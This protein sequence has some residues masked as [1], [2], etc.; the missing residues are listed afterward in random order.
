MCVRLN[1]RV[2]VATL[3]PNVRSS[4]LII[5]WLFASKEDAQRHVGLHI[6]WPLLLFDFNQI[7]NLSQTL[8]K[9]Y[10][11]N[12][13]DDPFSGIFLFHA[14]RQTDG[15]TI[16][17][18]YK[19]E[20][21]ELIVWTNYGSMSLPILFTLGL[22]FYPEDRG[23]RFFETWINHP[24]LLCILTLIPALIIILPRGWSQLVSRKRLQTFIFSLHLN[25]FLQF[26]YFN[27]KMEASGSSET[28]IN[29]IRC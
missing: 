22:P 25:N 27:L 21:S 19:L 18:T 9:L 16:G 10:T 17:R 20:G 14:H 5:V 29:R 7:W 28:W 6:K 12:V 23:S 15:W 8:T 1:I 3:V 24:P 11:V 26:A 4:I 2:C 13:N